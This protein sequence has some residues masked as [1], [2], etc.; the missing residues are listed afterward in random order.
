MTSHFIGFKHPHQPAARW[1]NAR[2]TRQH[3]GAR[4]TNAPQS[5][6]RRCPFHRVARLG[7]RFRISNRHSHKNLKTSILLQK[8]TIRF[9]PVT[10]LAS[11]VP[12]KSQEFSAREVGGIAVTA[13]ASPGGGWTP[14]RCNHALRTGAHSAKRNSWNEAWTDP[15]WKT[16][17]FRLRKILR[18]NTGIRRPNR[19]TK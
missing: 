2:L 15:V 16:E 6:A 14:S 17:G 10:S 11:S 13:F 1:W 4:G 19:H 12:V 7:K 5:Q 9:L 8:L 18:Q 3:T